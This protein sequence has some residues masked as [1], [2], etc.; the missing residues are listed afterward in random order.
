[1]TRCCLGTELTAWKMGV[2]KGAVSQK[3]KIL[4]QRG[5]LTSH[6]SKANKEIFHTCGYIFI[7]ENVSTFLLLKFIMKGDV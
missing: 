6:K 5:F 3:I 7:K 1:L 2:T 4:C